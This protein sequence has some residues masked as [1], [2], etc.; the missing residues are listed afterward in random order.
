MSS[1]QSG[2]RASAIG[3]AVNSLLA[4]TKVVAGVLGN[5]YALIADGIEST[6]DILSSLIVWGSLRIAAKPADEDHPFGH[7]KA[8]SMAG[9][10]VALALIGAAIG[11][12]I[13]SIR[14]IR[15]PHH[16][17]APFTLGVLLL[18]V[19]IKEWLYRKVAHT[20]KELG[21]TAL[22]ADAWHHRS[23]AITSA[24]AF[25]GIAIALLGGP[26]FESA[27]DYA[28]LV[29][30]AIISYNGYKLLRPA[31]DEIMDASP[32]PET[33]RQIRDTAAK[34]P[35]VSGIGRCR[36]RKS[37]TELFVDIHIK[38]PGEWS[39]H[40]GHTLAHGVEDALRNSF[41]RIKFVSVHVEPSSAS[42]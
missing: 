8:E 41:P 12:A 35:Q 10:A 19:F 42:N 33:V 25:V 21:S 30:C 14:E 24:T 1:L 38:V 31:V 32:T 22:S 34:V 18:V 11:I 39:V 27:D 13:Q 23:D 36:V 40:Q 4:T 26:G 16:A 2:I 37:G 9:L 3:I 6:A 5:S 15:T 17:P 7:G 20:G 29:A 28:A